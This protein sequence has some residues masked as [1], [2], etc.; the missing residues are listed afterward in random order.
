MAVK[1]SLGRTLLAGSA[2]VGLVAGLAGTA[3][4]GTALAGTRPAPATRPQSY[5]A[6]GQTGTAAQV[7]WQKVGPGWALAQ[8]S[9]DRSAGGHITPGPVT[10]YLTDPAGGKYQMHRWAASAKGA[11]V[12][13]AWSSNKVQ[14]LFLVPSAANNSIEQLDL[15]T[16][17]MTTIR[18]QDAISPIQSVTYAH[19]DGQDLLA[20]SGNYQ[21]VRTYSMTG[22][23]QRKLPTTFSGVL[24]SPDG[25]QFVEHAASGLRIFSGT[26]RTIRTLRVPGGICS[27]VRYWDSSSILAACIDVRAAE[28]ER[29]W[30]V[31]ADGGTPRAL[32][33][34]HPS[35]GDAGNLDAWQ[36]PGGTY[37][38]ATGGCGTLFIARQHANGTTSPVNVP[39]TNNLLNLIVTAQGGRLLVQAGTGC[40]SQNSLLWFNPANRH[41]DWLLRAGHD[42]SVTNVVPFPSIENA[43][44]A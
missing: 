22:V 5:L 10:L 38:Q 28:P 37:L 25:R 32:T 27:P 1:L 13:A 31:P 17:R 19:L 4:A 34:A 18:L 16:G 11:P 15:R 8:Y 36:L 23:L 12:L 41:E 7:P 26:G 33:S 42:G 35:A 9:E 21:P 24:L 44:L 39:G 14:A 40:A 6:A 43:P 29:L 3:L 30:I 2:A 20:I